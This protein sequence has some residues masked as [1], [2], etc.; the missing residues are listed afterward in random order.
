M[1]CVCRFSYESLGP[2]KCVEILKYV[3][4][5]I[6]NTMKITLI[7]EHLKILTVNERKITLI[8]MGNWLFIYLNYVLK[9]HV[10]K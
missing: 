8:Y 1:K 9:C 7:A 4:L 10:S 6:F 3:K 2:E 5:T